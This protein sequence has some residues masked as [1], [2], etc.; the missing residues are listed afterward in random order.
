MVIYKKYFFII[1]CLL[2]LIIIFIA[3]YEANNKHPEEALEN[4]S[5]IVEKG[6]IDSLT[7]TIYYM[8]THIFTRIPLTVNALINSEHNMQKIVIKGN[9]LKE[10]TDLFRQINSYVLHPVEK[11]SYLNARIYYVFRTKCGHRIFD[12][13]MRSGNEKNIY[14]N[15]H[16]FRGNDIFYDIILPFLPE[17]SADELRGWLSRGK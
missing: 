9:K 8:S 6:D 12:F 14:V 10:H 17:D 5:K 4:F 13:A 16:E 3:R 2:F 15:G 1:L 7:L 11:E